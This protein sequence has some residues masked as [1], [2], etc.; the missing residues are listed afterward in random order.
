MTTASVRTVLTPRDI[1]VLA[2]LARTPLTNDQLLRLSTT[3]AAPFRSDSRVRGRLLRMRAAGW[4][5]RYRYATSERGTPADYYKLTLAGY[6]ILQGE[7]AES[8]TKRFF[9]ELKLGRHHHAK[10]LADVLVHTA[11]SAHQSVIRMSD[12]HPE[13][14]LRLEI[15]SERL[16]PDGAFSLTTSS[17]RGFNFCLELDCGTEALRS[18]KDR[19]SIERKIRFYD[20]YQ[21]TASERFRVLFVVTR[22]E[23]RL[24]HILETAGK[25]VRNTRRSLCY[26]VLLEDSL[27]CPEALTSPCFRGQRVEPVALIPRE[28]LSSALPDRTAQ[29]MA[30]QLVRAG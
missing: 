20:R 1:D 22:S 18:T 3:F 14:T 26:G 4:V 8:P 2:W 9:D 6:R 7:S 24:A 23:D 15:G 21:D 28:P 10:S 27:R 25:V 29:V 11:T 30:S 12:I 16:Y 13:N 17:G 19:D 5:R